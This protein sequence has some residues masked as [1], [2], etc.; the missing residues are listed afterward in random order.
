[1][2]R[3]SFA[4][5]FA[6]VALTVG[7]VVFSDDDIKISSSVADDGK[8][9]AADRAFDLSLAEDSYWEVSGAF[10]LWLQ[11]EYPART[12]I[13]KYTFNSGAYEFSRMPYSW[14]LSGSN[15]GV[16]WESVD[17][18]DHQ[19]G[20]KRAE[21]RVYNTASK[22]EFKFFRF[23]FKSGNEAK[24]MRIYE[25][26]IDN[27]KG[28]PELSDK[29]TEPGSR[30]KISY[31]SAPAQSAPEAGPLVLSSPD[32]KKWRVTVDNSGQLKAVSADAGN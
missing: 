8:G 29:Y 9:H 15:D 17:K 24:N 31:S 18:Q 28:L 7:A 2:G 16:K 23:L 21:S 13:N 25:I 26:N 20:W 11:I 1:M 14:E 27:G 32:G 3:K 6:A 12:R 5:P 10:P 19:R 30:G 4:V 22:K